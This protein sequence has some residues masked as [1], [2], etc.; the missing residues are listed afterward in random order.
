MLLAL[1]LAPLGARA[2]D[3][4]PGP[5]ALDA[6]AA[7]RFAEL[8]LACVHREYPNKVSHVLQGDADARPPRAL[9]PA[10]ESASGPAMVP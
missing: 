7:G 1:L 2:A 8:A 6:A 3:A 5:P 9:T 10:L 4:P